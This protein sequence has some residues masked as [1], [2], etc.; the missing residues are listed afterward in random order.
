LSD[1]AD[2]HRAGLAALTLG[3]LGVVY[4]DIGTSPLYAFRETFHGDRLA[5]DEANVIGALS[6]VFWALILIVSV[7]YLLYV[8]RAD[9]KG[10]GG[11]LALTSLVAPRHGAVI[12]GRLK[13]L[14]L[15]G[16]FGTA[17]LYGDGVITPAISVL[18]AVEG[19]KVVEPSLESFVIPIAVGILVALFAVQK[20]GTG[21]VGKVFGPI[22]LVW[23]TVLGVLG[24]TNL[25]DDLSVLA[26]VNPLR[27]L[28]YL[29]SNG[30]A[31]FLSLGSIFLVVTGGEA[32][33][34]DMGHFGRSPIRTGWFTVALPC[35]MLNYFGQSAL[36]ISDPEAI[37]NPF[38]LMGPEWARPFL[39]ALATCATIIASQ[40]LISGAF[41][42]TVQAV[43]LDYLP[44]L[45]ISHTSAS[46]MG[47]VYVP[48]VNWLLML[49]SISLVL[50]FQTSSNLAAAYGIAVTGTMGVTT[51][52][53][54]SFAHDTWKWS[55]PK[56]L[57]V[58]VPLLVI[59]LAFFGAN[60]AKIPNG[61]WF[62]IVVAMVIIVAMTT[63]RTGRRILAERIRR[64]ETPIE[65]FLEDAAASGMPRVPGTAVFLF[66]GSG[67][68]PPALITNTRHNHVLHER[69]ILLSILTDDV[70]T[71]DD[72][73]RAEIQEYG[74][75]VFQVTLHYGFME[76]PDVEAALLKLSDDR[77]P[78][79]AESLTFFLGRETVIASTIPGMSNWRERLFAFQ[80]RS[81]ASA[82][83]FFRL[84]AD[85]V[86]E[87]G[88]Q[89]EI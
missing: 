39:V 89:V 37:E 9:N 13:W 8:L 71:V 66:K 46:H 31:G 35:L 22:M 43:Q 74:N 16:L 2:N 41:S 70:P 76:E 45:A 21:A 60:V 28:D 51:I 4:G 34:A 56:V 44:R 20:R 49:G 57:A 18:S 77:L 62:P 30:M 85:R 59:D 32:L 58:T 26:A 27:G 64:G 3:A 72:S 54:A 6:L 29:F 15:L 14:V 69:V 33:Y 24:V 61:G 68:A 1:R 65:R 36:L 84:P 78:I 48:I 5:V 47:Q 11:I 73:Q 55:L 17:L 81:A 10:E 40:A 88:S 23:F 63:W 79:T 52:L 87:V 83:R 53:M 80:L 12:I 50:G 82:A 75:G 19:L 67:A 25:V 38:F 42:M 86:V 7:K